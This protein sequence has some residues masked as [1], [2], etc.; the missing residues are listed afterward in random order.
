MPIADLY[1]GSLVTRKPPFG[2]GGR[3]LN[4][5]PCDEPDASRGDALQRAR[6]VSVG[7]YALRGVATPQ[8]LF[9]PEPG[10]I[11]P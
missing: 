2:K 4:L 3:F 9:T 10:F 5:P 1:L 11:L 8:E 7:R 6:V